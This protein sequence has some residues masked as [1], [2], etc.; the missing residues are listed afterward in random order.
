[1]TTELPEMTTEGKVQAARIFFSRMGVQGM[2]MMHS[3]AMALCAV[4]CTTG[5]V[6]DVGNRLQIVPIYNVRETT[7]RYRLLFVFVFVLLCI[8]VLVLLDSS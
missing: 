7:S 4:S 3:A 6:V 5:L 2:G 8:Y 1:M